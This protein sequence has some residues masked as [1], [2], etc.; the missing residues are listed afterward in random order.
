MFLKQN[1]QDIMIPIE[2]YTTI[3]IKESLKEAILDMRKIYCEV[4]SG[5]CTEAGHRN[6]LV[7][8]E[9]GHLA[10]VIDFPTILEAL[11]PSVGEEVA[12][13]LTAHG[14]A[15]FMERVIKNA[16]VMVADVMNEIKGSLHVD[17]SL[18]QAV[19][20]M[21]KG[22][23]TVLPVYQ[24]SKLVGVLRDSDLFLAVAAV[25]TD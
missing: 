16:D 7:M 15:G 1:V 6:C 22:R 12:D 17:D 4:E 11:I 23:T 3:S 25:F 24:G 21:H 10:G 13:L 18:L 14:K 9:Y 20:T 5:K 19:R 2:N 8:N